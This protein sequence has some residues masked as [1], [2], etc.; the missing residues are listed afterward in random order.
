MPA[1]GAVEVTR[2]IGSG[3]S[4]RYERT[5]FD[6]LGR[7]ATRVRP[8][9]GGT[10]TLTTQNVY[11]TATGLLEKRITPGLGDTF[12]SYDP[13]GQLQREGIDVDGGSGLQEASQDRIV[14]H[15]LRFVKDASN[16]WWL[17]T[18]G[19]GFPEANQTTKVLLTRSRE[20]L[21]GFSAGLSSDTF[22]WGVNP[23]PSPLDAALSGPARRTHSV[24]Y[25]ADKRI[26][27]KTDYPD[28]T[29]DDT[30]VV[31]NGRSTESTDTAGLRSTLTYDALGRL[32]Q[33]DEWTG[34][35]DTNLGPVAVSAQFEYVT[36]SPLL[37]RRKERNG[38]GSWT[39]VQE[40]GYYAN[41]ALKWGRGADGRYTRLAYNSRGQL[42]H[43]WGDGVTPERQ[44]YDSVYGQLT[45][46]RTY[47][48]GSGWDTTALPS[49]FTGAG[50]ASHWTTDAA[51]GL[52]TQQTDAAGRSESWAYDAYNRELTHTSPRNLNRTLSYDSKTGEI[53]GRDYSDST[54]D[55]AYS[56]TRLGLLNTVT[57]ATGTRTFHHRSSP[58][59]KLSEE[60]LPPG[61]Y[62]TDLRLRPKYNASH[63]RLE[64]MTL[65]VATGPAPTAFTSTHLDLTYSF[66][67]GSA[68]LSSLQSSTRNGAKVH[69]FSLGYLG[70]SSLIS[71]VSGPQTNLWRRWYEPYRPV[72]RSVS[73]ERAGTTYARY[74]YTR[75]D[76]ARIDLEN[77]DGVLFQGYGTGNAITIDYDYNARGQLERATSRVNN[78]SYPI[79]DRFFEVNYDH[80]A[81]RTADW[82]N[83]KDT[84]HQD[85]Y[86][87][88]SL[89]QY[90]SRGNR[91][92]QNTRCFG[93]QGYHFFRLT[94]PYAGDYYP[95]AQGGGSY[96]LSEIPRPG[97][98]AVAEVVNVEYRNVYG[99]F[100]ENRKLPYRR[101]AE[102]FQYDY[103]GNLT[104]EDLYAYQY[105]AED[106]LTRIVASVST[107]ASKDILYDYLGRRV[108]EKDYAGSTLVKWRRFIWDGWALIAEVDVNVSTQAK[109]VSQTFTWGPDVS[110]SI[111]GAGNIGGLLLVD[112][113]STEQFVAGD[114]G[115]G[116]VTTLLDAL[117]TSPSATVNLKAGVEYG[118]F[119]EIHR[120]TGDLSLLPFRFQSK[121]ALGRFWQGT[122]PPEHLD[123]GRR[124]YSP[125]FGRFLSRDPVGES[126]GANLYHYC[127][128]DPVNWIDPLGLSG[129]FAEHPALRKWR[130]GF[131]RLDAFALAGRGSWIRVWHPG[132]SGGDSYM[133]G[134]SVDS[135]PKDAEGRVEM[136]PMEVTPSGYLMWYWVPGRGDLGAIA[137]KGWGSRFASWLDRNVSAPL[138]SRVSSTWRSGGLRSRRKFA[139]RSHA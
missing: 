92:Y 63:A 43:R 29:N 90:N 94:S 49:G 58:D 114:D 107:A 72:L 37:L 61:F 95:S 8:K 51:T 24:V 74:Q 28:A 19:F 97:S 13:F 35:S 64:G 14:E 103:A 83:V 121:W 102:T 2:S 91:G 132:S 66:E 60:T 48:G 10:G 131:E 99:G 65:G 45:D 81:N 87:P 32:Q 16:H 128:N 78:N 116:N 30:S 139:R 3:S 93:S 34:N 25:P 46:L 112:K 133:Q 55:V 135:L 56:Y 120:N 36:G 109:S 67:S 15:D 85:W 101:A 100:Y 88:T 127:S 39:T 117:A 54:P 33:S 26:E 50:D 12:F 57:D 129:S 1:D 4:P 23:M 40:N 75:D 27:T 18:Q 134:G 80:A 52:P 69:S 89:N 136:L 106:R 115:R 7:I 42:T 98:S 96:L 21:T 6:L 123:F 11:S 31:V 137:A 126:A 53:L 20:R 41:G 9:V 108:E 59:Y 104:S 130:D 47:R 110:G 70:N 38:G 73:I 44:D 86:T 71:T 76:L 105:D 22:A 138:S 118:P 5:T 113:S 84:A 119:G 77:Q 124:A 82:R 125:R 79:A 62:G 17:Q 68:R 111:Q 122:V